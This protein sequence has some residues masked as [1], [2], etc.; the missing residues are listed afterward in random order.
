MAPVALLDEGSFALNSLG[1]QS[2]STEWRTESQNKILLFSVFLIICYSYLI[3]FL[4]KEWRQAEL[5][6]QADHRTDTEQEEAPA[7][8]KSIMRTGTQNLYLLACVA[9]LTLYI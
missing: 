2:P 6:Y 7:N 9:G 1:K 3:Y 4:N 8:R 5:R